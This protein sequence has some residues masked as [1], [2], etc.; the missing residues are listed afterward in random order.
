[1]E[2]LPQDK[3][4]QLRKWLLQPEARLLRGH[5]AALAASKAVEATQ[6]LAEVG[7]S[8]AAPELARSAAKEAA[9]YE[10]LLAV[11]DDLA[12]SDSAP[13]RTR[14]LIINPQLTEL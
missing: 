11:L 3:A 14:L 10:K 6:N 12:A 2:G 4:A 5:L 7:E 8:P 13:M 9:V 1:M